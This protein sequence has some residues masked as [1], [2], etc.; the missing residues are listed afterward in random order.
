[1]LEV[2]LIPWIQQLWS[3][4]YLSGAD[5]LRDHTAVLDP[6]R[7]TY[8]SLTLSLT[9]LCDRRSH[10]ALLFEP[11]M[12]LIRFFAKVL[13]EL[14]Y[15][16]TVIIKA[17]LES[18]SHLELFLKWICTNLYPWVRHAILGHCLHV[19]SP[20]YQYQCCMTAG[21]WSYFSFSPHVDLSTTCNLISQF[22]FNSSLI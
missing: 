6:A 17:V 16:H 13:W 14:S 20:E 12:R 22:R 5:R 8:C 7:T 10:L 15:F 21:S 4:H 19:V 1:M 3:L 9:T 18:V 2:K 11:W